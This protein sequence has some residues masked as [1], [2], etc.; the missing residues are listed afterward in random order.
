MGTLFGSPTAPA[1]VFMA[2]ALGLLLWCSRRDR[3]LLPVEE[4]AVRPLLLLLSRHGM[5]G[6]GDDR[7]AAHVE[8]ILIAEAAGLVAWTGPGEALVVTAAGSAQ[9]ARRLPPYAASPLA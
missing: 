8:A 4:D 1:M 7:L 2:L 3:R 5:I 9:L 6:D